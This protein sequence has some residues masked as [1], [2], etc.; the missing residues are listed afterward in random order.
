ME[1]QIGSLYHSNNLTHDPVD[2][3]IPRAMVN[4]Y[5]T[6]NTTQKLLHS[7]SS[8]VGWLIGL[9]LTGFLAQRGHI[10]PSKS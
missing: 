4:S 9:G 6:N 1:K 5:I 8:M 7:Y 3:K 2:H 10:M